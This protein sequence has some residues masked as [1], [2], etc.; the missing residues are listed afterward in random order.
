MIEGG[1]DGFLR[2]PCREVD[3]LEE[4]RKHL[5][6]DY[7]YAQAESRARDS[8]APHPPALGEVPAQV[9]DDGVRA[10]LVT[11]ARIADYD[12]LMELVN[13]IPTEHA[14]VGAA[15]RELVEGYAYQEIEAILQG[16]R[17]R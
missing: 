9:L 7:R 10:E 1:A 2:K 14:Q 6:I 4:V 16:A 3:L 5:G 12:R 13:Q 8:P 15:L 11:A 17:G